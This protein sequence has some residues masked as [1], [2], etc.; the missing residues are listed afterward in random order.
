MHGTFIQKKPL[1]KQF[2]YV[3]EDGEVI[4]F[5]IEVTRGQGEFIQLSLLNRGMR[6]AL[7]RIVRWR[8][9]QQGRLTTCMQF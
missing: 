1:Q 5:G 3:V 6:F 9:T 7:D 8:A 2:S 4:T